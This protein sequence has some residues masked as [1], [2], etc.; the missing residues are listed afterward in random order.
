MT[1]ALVIALAAFLASCHRPQHTGA[2][3][4]SGAALD[5]GAYPGE[6]RPVDALEGDFLWRQRVTAHWA[7]GS[8]G[9]DAAL[10]KQLGRLTLLGLSPMGT[11][12]FTLVLTDDGL[13][14]DNR[15]DRELPF[16]PRFIILDLQRVFYPWLD[17]PPPASGE[18]S[19]QVA[20]ERVH[21]RY[22]RG[23]LIER[24][25]ER[26]DQTPPGLIRVTY[27]GYEPEAEAPARAELHNAWFGYRIVVETSDQQRL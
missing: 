26:L 12:G 15:T 17:G 9:F 3:A 11:P 1:R 19:G 16:P 13:T 6:L 5:P 18:R 27:E 23:R 20:G 25:F 2:Q 21:E 14:F 24:T 10:Q 4:D 22:D 7:V 8:R